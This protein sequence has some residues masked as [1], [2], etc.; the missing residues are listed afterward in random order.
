MVRRSG[1]VRPL[2][3]SAPH[4][5]RSSPPSVCPLIRT[6]KSRRPDCPRPASLPDQLPLGVLRSLPTHCRAPARGPLSGSVPA[7]VVRSIALARRLRA[8]SVRAV[9]PGGPHPAAGKRHL[10][11][12]LPAPPPLAAARGPALS[13]PLLHS[14]RHTRRA[15]IFPNGSPARL[16]LRNS[17]ALLRSPPPCAP[18]PHFA[19]PLRTAP[20]HCLSLLLHPCRRSS[21]R[22]TVAARPLRP[23]PLHARPLLL[24]PTS[25]RAP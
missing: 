24:L 13:P 15:N 14:A 5:V 9:L 6:C 22:L 3:G 16:I 1:R 8:A 20:P 23:L 11:S 17:A 7:V 25:P 18:C 2:S 4:R 21:P 10:L 12:T 19:P